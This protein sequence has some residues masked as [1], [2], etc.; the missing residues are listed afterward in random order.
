MKRL[1]SSV[2]V[3]P[4]QK[5]YR[6]LG[7]N[8]AILDKVW[9][10]LLKLQ[11]ILNVCNWKN[12]PFEAQNDLFLVKIRPIW[13]WQETKNFNF[14]YTNHIS[15]KEMKKVRKL[16]RKSAKNLHFRN[17]K[18]CKSLTLWTFKSIALSVIPVHWPLHCISLSGKQVTET[19]KKHMC[20]C[21]FVLL[22]PLVS[23]WCIFHI[24]CN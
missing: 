22:N 14:N 7:H 11:E 2:D 21:S 19:L 15:T 20:I 18:I 9:P 3:S 16:K 5:L 23:S 10:P 6:Y 13:E 1:R 12:E 17:F 4:R 8:D 24:S